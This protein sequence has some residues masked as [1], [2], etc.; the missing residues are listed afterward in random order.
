MDTVLE[1]P[2]IIEFGRFRIVPQR[3]ELLVEGRPVKLGGRAFD[4]LMALVEAR[5]AVVGKDAL[6]RRVWPGQIVEDNNLQAQISLLRHAFGADRDLIR[7]VAGRG[8]QFSGEVRTLAPG[9]FGN[10]LDGAASTGPPSPRPP[11]NLAEP[12]AELIGREDEIGEVLSLAAAHRLV[13]LTGAGGIGKTRL[14]VAVAQRLLSRYADGVWL[15]ELAPLADPALVPAAVAA[16][17]GLKFP[18]GEVTAERVAQ[19]LAAK[20]LL[21]V[22]DN[23]EHVIGA[24]AAIVEAVLRANPEARVV[25]TSREPLRA[26]GEWLYPVPPLAVPAADAE[27]PEELLRYAAVRLFVAR[28]RATEPHFSLDRRHA[29]AVAAICRRLDGLPLAIELAAAR[30]AAL[31]VEEIAAHLDDRFRLLTGGR[32]TALPRHQTLRAT[33]DWSYDLL[34][35]PER[36]VLRRLAVFPDGF[37]LEAASAVAA[38]EEIAA[39][40]VVAIVANLVAKSLVSAEIDGAQPRYRLLDTTRAY[41]FEKLGQSG[42]LAA[43]AR[44]HAEHVRDAFERAAAEWETRPTAD[45]L[46]EY[47]P[48]LCDVRAALDWALSAGGDASIGVTLTA[49]AIPLW[50]DFCLL[51]ECRERAEQ[52]LSMLGP[53]T[54]MDARREMRLQAAFAAALAYTRGAVPEVGPAWKRTLELAESLDD[55]DYQLRALRGLFVR[56]SAAR[57]YRSALAFA[58]R[59]RALAAERSDRADKLV[60]DLL[61]AIQQHFIGDQNNAR[62]HVERMLAFYAAPLRRSHI[63]RFQRDQRL[64]ALSLLARILWLQGFPDQA[65]ET[66]YGAVA[67]AEAA[68]H[69]LSL[70]GTL[71]DAA[72]PIALAVGDLVAAQRYVRMLLDH[73]SR[74]ALVHWHAW[75]RKFEGWLA[76]ERGDVTTGLQ[77]MRAGSDER[78]EIRLPRLLNR[79]DGILAEALGRAGEIAEGLAAIDAAITRSERAEDCMAIAQ[80]LRV[81]GELLLLQGAPGAA[82]A[83][84]DHFRQALDWARRQG[85]LSWELPAATS[86]ARLLREEGRADEAAALLAPVYDR[87][88][89]GFDTADLR[90]A[91]ALLD[92]LR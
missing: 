37:R 69:A 50:M 26:D 16:A 49:A 68:D 30:A 78:V 17:L 90:A 71:A 74:H 2:A 51:D 73:S 15:I 29:A 70:C 65:V 13:T 22:L 86:L 81:K 41:A 48:R 53:G 64:I 1:P 38:G 67:E 24:A 3:R 46:A 44:R 23:C 25:A 20:Q 45:W 31:G 39:S 85:A 66:A 34:A 27:D 32:R 59:F 77:L 10:R 18:T 36:V 19:A 88:T 43:V 47:A 56:H 12:I 76:I 7:T 89:E 79:L 58:R 61:I 91:K 4:V 63:I 6:M 75:G 28:M 54:S 14:A 60:G 35:E 33:L 62:R 11:T 87:F 80:F 55:V 92:A 21:L 9:S 57:A 52:A 82:A 42:D 83:A 84:A 72:C 8:Y 5:G 40:D